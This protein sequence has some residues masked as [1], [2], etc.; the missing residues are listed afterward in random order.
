MPTETNFKV[1]SKTKKLQ[2][3]LILPWLNELKRIMVIG[4]TNQRIRLHALGDLSF[5]CSTRTEF[6]RTLGYGGEILSLAS[7]LF[8][9]KREDIVWDVGASV[10]LFTMHAVQRVQR[11]IAFE[12][13]PE[14]AGRLRKNVQLNGFMEKVD[15]LQVALGE[16]E[17]KKELHT[18]GLGGLAPALGNLKRHSGAVSVQVETID[19]IYQQD[20]QGPTVLKIDIEGAEL[21]ALRGAKALL[22]SE[23]RPRIIFLELHPEFLP[24]FGGSAEEVKKLIRDSGYTILST[25]QRAEQQHLI[26]LAPKNGDI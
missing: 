12:P 9:L 24:S 26:A 16:E 25:E 14:T 11:V 17:G 2:Q 20:A 13:D 3:R 18:D 1:V 15:I 22:H 4:K 6:A 10:G 19:R 8:L 23:Q 21:L 5:I 7:F